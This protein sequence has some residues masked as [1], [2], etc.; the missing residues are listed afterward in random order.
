MSLSG[1]LTDWKCLT[2]N[3]TLVEKRCKQS[4]VFCS[5]PGPRFFEAFTPTAKS[6]NSEKIVQLMTA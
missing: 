3:R 1:I 4:G 5:D 2:Y 6:T